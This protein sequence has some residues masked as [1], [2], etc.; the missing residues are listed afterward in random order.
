MKLVLVSFFTFVEMLL[1]WNAFYEK[2]SYII[3]PDNTDQ[4]HNDALEVS[5]EIDLTGDVW[6][7]T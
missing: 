2:A 7:Q 3:F 5:L 1:C 6:K 4:P